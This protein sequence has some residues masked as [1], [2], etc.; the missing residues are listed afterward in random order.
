MLAYLC[1]SANTLPLQWLTTRVDWHDYGRGRVPCHL[2]EIAI[3]WLAGSG[4]GEVGANNR[5]ARTGQDARTIG[6][7]KNVALINQ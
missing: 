5:G 3:L 7:K 1:K 2:A 4:M 6:Q